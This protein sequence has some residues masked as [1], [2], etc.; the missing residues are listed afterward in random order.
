MLFTYVHQNCNKNDYK[1][2]FR[3]VFTNFVQVS[4]EEE[5]LDI[6]KEIVVKLLGSEEL[7]VGKSKSVLP[8]LGILESN[9][10]RNLVSVI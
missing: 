10:R 9:W 1:F 8:T 4:L 6:P 3:F 5:F 2:Y 7:R